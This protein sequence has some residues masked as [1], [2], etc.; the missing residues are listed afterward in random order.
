VTFAFYV[1][2]LSVYFGRRY[3][4]SL[5]GLPWYKLASLGSLF[6][7]MLAGAFSFLAI[8]SLTQIPGKVQLFDV[9]DG[10]MIFG[11]LFLPIAF[12]LGVLIP[13]LEIASNVHFHLTYA[14]VATLLMSALNYRVSQRLGRRATAVLFRITSTHR[15]LPAVIGF[16][17]LLVLASL[18]NIG[19]LGVDPIQFE[20]FVAGAFAFEV[21]T[22]QIGLQVTLFD[23]RRRR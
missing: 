1:L 19:I 8:I 22:V 4:A 13:G 3:L 6:A 14:F 23:L 9:Y 16:G 21:I 2:F 17:L 11:T 15:D 18:A 5:I 20:M 12:A 10:M 7:F